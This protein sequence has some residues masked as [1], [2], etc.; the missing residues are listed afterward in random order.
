M[1]ELPE[2]E[3]LRLYLISQGVVGRTIT[4]AAADWPGIESTEDGMGGL[5]QLR[6][7]VI[8][9]IGRVGKNLLVTLDRGVLWL[10]M[11]MTGR[12]AVMRPDDEPLRYA[13]TTF[14]LDDER[15]IELDDPRRWAGVRLLESK[16]EVLAGIGP[17]ALGASL[18]EE[19]FIRR[20]KTRRSPVK[21]VLMDQSV[22]AGVGNI[23]ADEALHRAGIRPSRRA[24]RISDSRLADLR[25]AVRTCL[26]QALRYIVDHPDERGR[27]FVVDAYDDRMRLERK[28]NAV[29]PDC[30]APL[31]TQKIGGRASYF[32]PR[33][34]T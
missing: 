20:V 18:T 6:G 22:L 34:Q 4:D 8:A 5:S 2:V 15:R 11:G 1:P 7:R 12:L 31:R 25:R 24:D 9:G 13:R 21:S 10:H 27:P 16:S 32:C 14:Y 19:E 17:D 26:L 28:K 3:S 29:C 23:Y 33:C 30:S